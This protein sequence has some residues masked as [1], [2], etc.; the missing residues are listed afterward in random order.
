MSSDRR[1]T[2]EDVHPE[3]SA[4]IYRQLTQGKVIL[5]RQYNQHKGVLEDSPQFNLLFNHLEHFTLLYRHIGYNLNYQTQGEF[6]YVTQTRD[7]EIDEADDN[8]LKV[9]VV[10]LLIGRYF[11]ASGRDLELLAD[12]N[13]GLDDIDLKR[14]AENQEYL[15]VLRTVRFEKGWNEALEFLI[16]RNFAFRTGPE[17][18][19]LSD[20]SMSFLKDL[21]R[22][23][24]EAAASGALDI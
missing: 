6:F 18:Y 19:V 5:K 24:E 3:A 17:S 9:Q 4:E 21:E 20:A 16:R 12:P 8:A 10:V 15:D 1:N 14:L 22:Y 23:Y 13:H 11:S 7:D 2:F